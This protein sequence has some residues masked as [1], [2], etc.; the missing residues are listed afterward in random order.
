[1]K[2]PLSYF[3]LPLVCFAG[4]FQ[5][6]ANDDDVKKEV[7]RLRAE[8]AY[9]EMK[10]NLEDSLKLFEES[11]VL[12][13]DAVTEAKVVKIKEELGLI[14]PTPQE[15]PAPAAVPPEPQEQAVQEEDPTG[16]QAAQQEPP[17]TE[18]DEP[19]PAPPPAEPD[20]AMQ[21]PEA[22][23]PEPQPAPVQ[24][25]EGAAAIPFPQALSFEK[26]NTVKS[27]SAGLLGSA[28]RNKVSSLAASPDFQCIVWD[29]EEETDDYKTSRLFV[30]GSEIELPVDVRYFGRL[31][32]TSLHDFVVNLHLNLEDDGPDE[33]LLYNG[34]ILGNYYE[35][36]YPTL[37]EDKSTWATAL[38]D[39]TPHETEGWYNYH[40]KLVVNGE[41]VAE[42]PCRVKEICLSPD[43]KKVA[44]SVQVEH[45]PDI[46]EHQSVY[47]GSRKLNLNV[48]TCYKLQW[49]GDGE[50]LYWD[51]ESLPG[52][53]GKANRLL[54]KNEAILSDCFVNLD[55]FSVTHDSKSYAYPENADEGYYLVYN[56]ERSGP[57]Q[58]IDDI[59]LSSEGRLGFVGQKQDVTRI[60]IDGEPVGPEVLNW[61]GVRDLVW[62]PDGKHWAADVTIEKDHKLILL[63]GRE[64]ATAVNA[65]GHV[66]SPDSSRLASWIKNEDKTYA[67][68]V[69]DQVG[70]NYKKFET[71]I[72][73]VFSPD[74][75]HV[76]NWF[77]EDQQLKLVKDLVTIPNEG[78]TAPQLYFEQDGSTWY[79]E[80]IGIEPGEFYLRKLD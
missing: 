5:L 28:Y 43:G 39:R 80:I 69:D 4:A 46:G 51:A 36:D 68:V 26:V 2:I 14:E 7:R 29:Q 70:P 71:S 60:Y 52:E 34:T 18:Q 32:V 77:T 79:L 20:P 40:S 48:K 78:D 61:Y 8:A 41:I 49:D 53:D 15:S 72:S 38:I 10:G 21:L 16:T 19:I 25:E 74:S 27:R 23:T 3:L 54:V 24:P 13:P 45:D 50:N 17:A 30:N 12:M 31:R 47:I 76:Y 56:G 67:I 59:A 75:K 58:Q 11:L 6:I 62:S 33:A 65:G 9:Q 1:M 42:V 57:W 37:S 35:V 66:F 44:F 63:D 55:E 73:F 64:T 22:A